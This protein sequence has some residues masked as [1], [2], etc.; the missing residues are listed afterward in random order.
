MS[1]DGIPPD[2]LEF[3]FE[4]IDSIDQLDVML[5]LRTHRS[6]E[7]TAQQVSDELRTNPGLAASRLAGLK[8]IGVLQDNGAS[9]L[10]YRYSPATSDLERIVSDLAETYRVRRH[11]V[12]ELIYSSLKRARKF[13]DAFTIP[14]PKVGDHD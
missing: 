12:Y 8:A 2:V 13:L 7:W 10:G 1:H 6:R 11:K 4:H 5:L 14:E 3:I 9:P